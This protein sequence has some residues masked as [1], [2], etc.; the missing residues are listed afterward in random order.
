MLVFQAQRLTTKY[1]L[2]CRRDN[3]YSRSSEVE[4]KKIDKAICEEIGSPLRFQTIHRYNRNILRADLKIRSI[5]VLIGRTAIITLHLLLEPLKILQIAD[6]RVL[7]G[8]ADQ[9]ES[10]E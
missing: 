7:P 2:L 3:Q 9:K 5:D 4:K 8:G 1:R 6:H 10:E